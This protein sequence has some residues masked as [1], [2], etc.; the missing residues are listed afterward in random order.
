[1][2]IIRGNGGQATVFTHSSLSKV[3]LV[4]RDDEGE[5]VVYLTPQRARRLAE[6]LQNASERAEDE[7]Q[8]GESK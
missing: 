5:S 1:M 2:R 4:V 3:E 6:F 8:F 7:D